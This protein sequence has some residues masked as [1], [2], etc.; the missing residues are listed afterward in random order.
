MLSPSLIA[1][2]RHLRSCEDVPALLAVAAARAPEATGFTSA[3]VLPVVDGLPMA[4]GNPP[5]DVATTADRLG[6]THRMHAEI[7]PE[8]R[9]LALLLVGRE[10]GP[11]GPEDRAAVADL[12][13]V[14][15][16][17]VERVVLRRRAGELAREVRGFADLARGM[18]A[19]VVDAPVALPT[20][21]GLG[22]ALPRSTTIVADDQR[23]LRLSGR[24]RR[25]AGL[26]VDGRSNR[27][28][29]QELL[30][31]PETVKTHVARTLRKLGAA[32]RVEAVAVLLGR[33]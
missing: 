4:P 7:R 29:A 19:D 8:D 14:V 31:S 10:T 1:V 6:L 32:N 26:L 30:L 33:T 2:L 25:I 11:P 13:L 21:H 16:V 22:A 9:A 28:I 5:A 23:Y 3:Y 24:E 17:A 15:A 27:E 20:D 18:T 12:A